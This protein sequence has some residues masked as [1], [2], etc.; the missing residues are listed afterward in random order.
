MHTLANAYIFI[1]DMYHD[2]RLKY[3][4]RIIS[5]NVYN[6]YDIR[7]SRTRS[8]FQK[9]SHLTKIFDGITTAHSIF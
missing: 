1:R 5:K 9:G 3:I 8:Q 6:M 7:I 2:W 4:L